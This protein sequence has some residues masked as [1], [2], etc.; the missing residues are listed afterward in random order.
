MRKQLNTFFEPQ[1]IEQLALESKFVQ[2]SGLLNG[3]TFLCLLAINSDDLATESLNDLATKLEL[4]YGINIKRQSLDERFNQ[5]A[6]SFL[7]KAVG[8]LLNRQCSKVPLMCCDQFK[9]ILIKDS[10]C[11]QVDAS[12]A[13]YFPGCGG[14]GSPATVRIQF[15]YD[16]V[17]GKIVDLSLNGFTEQDATNST[18]TLDVVNEGDLV[19]RDLAYMHITALKGILERLGDFLCRLQS[20][21]QVYQLQDD[22]VI[23]LD[24][25]RIVRTIEKYE[26]DKIEEKVFLDRK[27]TLEVRLFIYLLPL[28][29]Y[30][31]RMRKAKLNA[32]KKG[33]QLSKK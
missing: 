21:R 23:E 24:F 5:Y 3:F 16:L 26:I 29:V 8:E 28:D 7:K 9:R 20:N 15:E 27:M 12:F 31:E 19:I 11:F 30:R 2:R 22:K 4:G 13:E 17:A 25:V 10:V 14:S 18:M 32:K 33:R 6:V 1:E